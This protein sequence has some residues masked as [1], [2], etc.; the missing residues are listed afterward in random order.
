MKS[1]TLLLP[2]AFGFI[3]RCYAA[4]DVRVYLHPSPLH[5]ANHD[6]TLA[7]EEASRAVAKFVGLELFEPSENEGESE[8][9]MYANYGAGEVQLGGTGRR[10]GFELDDEKGPFVG[11]GMGRSLVINI[12]GD[13]NLDGVFA[14]YSSQY[15]MFTFVLFTQTLFHTHFL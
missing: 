15:C 11:K 10:V 7:P 2:V 8:M 5:A 1:T 14:H 4:S 12:D 9:E 3:A 13:A 6:L